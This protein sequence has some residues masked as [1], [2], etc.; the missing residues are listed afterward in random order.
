MKKL[1]LLTIGL[2]LPISVIAFTWEYVL[3]WDKLSDFYSSSQYLFWAWTIVSKEVTLYEWH[4]IVKS[5]TWEV[6]FEVVK[7]KEEPIIVKKDSKYREKRIREISKEV[8]YS[9]PDLAVRI[10]K[11]ESGLRAD[12]KNPSSTATGLFQ[13]LKRYRP[14]RAAKYWY[15][16]AD[17][18]DWEANAYVSISMLRDWWLSHWYASKHCRWK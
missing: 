6:V 15:A 5:W 8:W 11:C 2:I 1:F 13:H 18:K 12:A 3:T 10:A 16:W 7:Q 4:I 9:N 14:A 17:R